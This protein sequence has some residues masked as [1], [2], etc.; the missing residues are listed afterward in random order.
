MKVIYST[1]ILKLNYLRNRRENVRI[2]NLKLQATNK[3]KRTKEN[4][5]NK[6]KEILDLRFSGY[7][8]T[9]ELISFY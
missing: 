5:K 4:K 8:Y 6:R 3:I 1:I 9:R 7:N 2:F